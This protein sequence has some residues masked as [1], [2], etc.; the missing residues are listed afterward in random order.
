MTPSICSAPTYYTA[1]MHAREAFLSCGTAL[2]LRGVPSSSIDRRCTVHRSRGS[3]IE[4]A[5]RRFCFRF[6]LISRNVYLSSPPRLSHFLFISLS[7]SFFIRLLNDVG[8]MRL[9]PAAE[10]PFLALLRPLSFEQE[11]IIALGA[12]SG[13]M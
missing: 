8:L 9:T 7:C 11:I 1:D 5:N 4:T 10:P 6:A 3:A 12:V 13:A 2:A